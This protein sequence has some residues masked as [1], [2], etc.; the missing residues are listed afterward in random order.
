VKPEVVMMM[1]L[2]NSR[3]EMEPMISLTAAMSTL[4]CGAYRLAWMATRPPSS[5]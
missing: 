2:V 4:L 3:W 5:G 1:P